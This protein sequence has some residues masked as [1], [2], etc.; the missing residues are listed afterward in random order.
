MVGAPGPCTRD[1]L[2]DPELWDTTR[3]ENDPSARIAKDGVRGSRTPR[4]IEC[5]ANTVLTQM[6][7]RFPDKLRVPYGAHWQ[8]STTTGSDGGAL[9]AA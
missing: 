3:V 8:R 4:Q 5:L 2:P 7:E 9:S 6:L 1:H